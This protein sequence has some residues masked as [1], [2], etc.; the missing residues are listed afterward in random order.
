MSADDADLPAVLLDAAYATVALH[1]RMTL[2]EIAQGVPARDF[3]A[4]SLHTPGWFSAAAAKGSRLAEVAPEL[5]PPQPVEGQRL[6]LIHMY[7]PELAQAAT[8][9]EP[10]PPAV[11][12][13][14][15][16]DRDARR[17]LAELKDLDD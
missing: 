13:V 5:A 15:S 10:P 2:P 4:R 1:Q 9:A 17:L 3:P 14:R 8:D 11:A 7:A 6:D 16:A 12:P